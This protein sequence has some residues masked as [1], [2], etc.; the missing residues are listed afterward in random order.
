MRFQVGCINHQRVGFATSVSQFQK[1]SGE[2]AL[3]APS[4]PAVVECL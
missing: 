4:F 3:V 2:Y 1:H